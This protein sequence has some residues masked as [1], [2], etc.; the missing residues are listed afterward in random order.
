MLLSIDFFSYLQEFFR[1]N[2]DSTS[3]IESGEIVGLDSF[4]FPSSSDRSILD[5]TLYISFDCMYFSFEELVLFSY[6]LEIRLKNEGHRIEKEG[7]IEYSISHR[8]NFSSRTVRNEITES[9]RRR[10]DHREVESIEI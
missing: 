1:E 5:N 2:D 6:F 7:D 8:E 4:R 3:T 9:D 10:R